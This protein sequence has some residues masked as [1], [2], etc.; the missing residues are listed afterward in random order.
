[1]WINKIILSIFFVSVSCNKIEYTNISAIQNQLIVFKHMSQ[2]LDLCFTN[3][4]NPIVMSENVFNTFR[5]TAPKSLKRPIMIISTNFENKD[6]QLHLHSHPTYVL[7]AQSNMEFGKLLI[8]L[9]SS[10]F[11]NVAS[12]F[13]LVLE[14]E[15]CDESAFTLLFILWKVNSLSSF[16][17]C[18]EIGRGTSLYIF[19]P[20]TKRAPDPWIEV[21]LIY[22][23]NP[24]FTAYRRPFSNDLTTCYNLD[25]DK[26]K[27]LD[28]YP[29]KVAAFTK[30]RDFIEKDVFPR[31]N[32]TVLKNIFQQANDADLAHNS[33]INDETDISQAQYDVNDAVD[34]DID[35]IPVTMDMRFIIVTQKKTYRSLVRDIVGV[36]DLYSGIAVIVI[37]LIITIMIILTNGYQIRLALLDVLKLLLSMGMDAPLDRFAMK[38]L[39]FTAFIFIF[40]FDPALQGQLSAILTRPP[41]YNVETLKDLYDHKYHLHYY[42]SLHREMIGEELWTTVEDMRFLHPSLEAFPYKCLKLATQDDTVACIYPENM[43][44]RDALEKQN[45][46]ISK[47]FLFQSNSVYLTRRDWPLKDQIHKNLLNAIESGFHQKF[48]RSMIKNPLKKKR[49]V[50]RIKKILKY[51]EVDAID[52]EY[53]YVFFAFIQLLAIL[54]F[55]IEYLIAQYRRRRQ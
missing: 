24:Q 51:D 52:L 22:E 18:H 31:L 43:T 40:T 9:R 4:T 33:L 30:Q 36:F 32:V 11:W 42:Q 48:D 27:F 7:T 29:I 1:M 23:P 13:F 21:E 19:N 49:K 3:V 25:F 34:E 2:L 46:Y 14:L 20:F 8:K 26:T 50:D 5:L 38:I 41:S 10:R 53:F 47:T 35:V 15:Q 55:G 28:R 6:I 44:I 54:I 45:L 12:T 16:V 37:L 39:F 17:V